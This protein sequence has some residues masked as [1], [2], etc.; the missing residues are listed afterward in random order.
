[1]PQPLVVFSSGMHQLLESL[2]SAVDWNLM[3]SSVQVLGACVLVVNMLLFIFLWMQ[4]FEMRRM[5][6]ATFDHMI[7]TK[8]AGVLRLLGDHDYVNWNPALVDVLFRIFFALLFLSL[9]FSLICFVLGIG[10]V[11]V[12]F[13]LTKV[14]NEVVGSLDEFCFDLSVV[15]VD[16]IACGDDFQQ[17]CNDGASANGKEILWSGF[18]VFVSHFYLVA[19]TGFAAHQ[20]RSIPSLL[21][22]YDLVASLRKNEKLK[23][24]A[25]SGS[26]PLLESNKDK[27]EEASG[28]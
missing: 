14:C 8:E 22:Q 28:S 6:Q 5:V 12:S 9:L 18:F 24:E 15:G 7:R 27:E 16:K 19:A 13:F 23:G 25:L 26:A 4:A 1:M 3:L 10:A 11:G 2:V 17:I 21:A 20:R